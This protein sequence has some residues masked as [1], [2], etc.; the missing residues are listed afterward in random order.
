MEQERRDLLVAVS[1]VL[2]KQYVDSGR[3]DKEVFNLWNDFVTM[4]GE[5]ENESTKMV[6]TRALDLAV[7]H[8]LDDINAIEM[9]LAWVESSELIV[10]DMMKKLDC[11]RTD[12]TDSIYWAADIDYRGN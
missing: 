4:C 7:R 9:D 11:M 2:M 1:K 3:T 12:L 8:I 6:E 10:S 5:L